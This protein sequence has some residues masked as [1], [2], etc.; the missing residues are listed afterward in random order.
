MSRFAERFREE[1]MQRGMQRGMQQGIQQGEVLVS[2]RL[3]RPKFGPLPDAV[4][5]RIDQADEQTLPE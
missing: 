3:L 4:Q 2:E 1:G 5:R